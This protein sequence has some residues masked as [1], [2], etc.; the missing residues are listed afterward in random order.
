L[1]RILVK[2]LAL[3]LENK[4]LRQWANASRTLRVETSIPNV[5]TGIPKVETGIP[6]VKTG[7]EEDA[8][9]AKNG[10]VL[11]IMVAVEEEVAVAAVDNGR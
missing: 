10:A 6:R 1:E 7:R 5:E 9:E 3:I 4:L 2:S 11:G 8:G